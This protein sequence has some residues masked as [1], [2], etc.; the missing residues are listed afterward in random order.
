MD[1]PAGRT[2]A[3]SHAMAD[4]SSTSDR[5]RTVLERRS[6]WVEI[7]LGLG[8]V[9][10]LFVV[11][12]FLS[13]YF[14][15]Y[16]RI[17]LIFFFAW[18]L[19]FLM[20][21]VADWLQHRVTRLPRPIAVILVLIPIIVV[22]AIV[23]VRILASVVDSLVGLT[24][25]LPGIAAN[26]PPILDQV[27][28][29]F[30]QQGIAVDVAGTFKSLVTGLLTGMVAIMGGMLG[31]LVASVGTFI[32]AIV[33]VSLAVFMA[34]DRD[35]ILR[36]GLDLTPPDKRDD[37]VL[38]RHSVGTA[39]AGFIR[40][41]ILLGALYGVWALL[42]SLLFGLPF[43]AATAAIAGL[44]MMIPIYGPYVSWTPPVL[45]ALLVKP[46][47]VILVAVVM[48]VGWFI[49][50]NILAPVVRAGALELH[51]IV[52]TFAFLLGGQ[53][54]GAI[55]A[56][57]AIPLAAV[58]QAFVVKYLERYRAQRGWPGPDEPS[59]PMPESREP[60]APEPTVAS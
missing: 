26:P 49:D 47:V 27:Q 58:V 18:L 32:D 7:L 37:A 43:A 53:L 44:I 9:A 6:E 4:P 1:D 14:A 59:S 54:A 50:E 11:L 5:L 36:I 13:R 33:V 31:G 39:A 8:I 48:L 16:L 3:T 28:A 42:T 51:P 35:K 24:A 2:V 60:S 52:V 30:D 22:S 25:A 56:I 20:S 45:V 10:L 38:F 12:E 15:D 21:P 19:A 41:Q 46:D 57:V 34:I 40:S 23:I 29:W 55:G 17:I